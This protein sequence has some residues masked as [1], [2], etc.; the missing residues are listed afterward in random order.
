MVGGP[1]DTVC[2][3]SRNCLY[4]ILHNSLKTLS[5][6]V[7]YKLVLFFFRLIFYKCVMEGSVKTKLLSGK[8]IQ[9]TPEIIA[10]VYRF[11]IR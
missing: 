10:N 9:S 7:C 1:I 4:V 6:R 2:C 8:M 11:M 5:V 3:H